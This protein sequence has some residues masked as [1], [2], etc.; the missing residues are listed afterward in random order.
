MKCVSLQGCPNMVPQ[1]RD[2]KQ[3]KWIHALQSYS[4]EGQDQ[5]IGLINSFQVLLECVPYLL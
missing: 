1:T 4:P 2:L 5:D 3:Q